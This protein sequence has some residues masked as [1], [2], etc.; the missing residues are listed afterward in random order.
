M[1]SYFGNRENRTRVGNCTSEWGAVNRG[2]PQGSSLGP[3]VWN[4]YQNDLLYSGVNSQLSAYADDHQLYQGSILT[5]ELN[6][7]MAS[8]WSAF[9]NHKCVSTRHPYLLLTL[10]TLRKPLGFRIGLSKT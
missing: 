6:S 5:F 9:S 1:R 3:L 10:K 8:T 2:C 7:Q 4:V